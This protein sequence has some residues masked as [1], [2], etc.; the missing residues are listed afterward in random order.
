MITWMSHNIA[1]DHYETNQV[2]VDGVPFVTN[3]FDVAVQHMAELLDDDQDAMDGDGS[4]EIDGDEGTYIHSDGIVKYKIVEIE[5]PNIDKTKMMICNYDMNDTEEQVIPLSTDELCT[6][7]CTFNRE[8]TSP[9][10]E[11]R[12]D[13]YCNY[14]ENKHTILTE[15][16]FAKVNQVLH[17]DSE[18]DVYFLKG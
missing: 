1:A 17:F 2:C 10:V 15:E 5:V 11:S 13:Y 4:H 7:M 18:H 8:I 12:K 6:M 3:D 16:F 14:P 9:S